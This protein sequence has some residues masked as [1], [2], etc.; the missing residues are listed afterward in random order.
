M[1]QLFGGTYSKEDLLQRIGHL[2]Q[3]GGV[4]LLEAADGPAR[5]VRRLQ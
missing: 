2:S 4:E 5:G 3:V 1:T